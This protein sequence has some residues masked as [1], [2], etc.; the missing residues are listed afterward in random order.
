MWN[1]A[2]EDAA[3][4]FVI[5]HEAE[6]GWTASDSRGR[7][8]AGDVVSDGDPV[9][10]VKPHGGSARWSDLWLVTLQVAVTT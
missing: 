1:R 4:E 2:A 9:I 3:I 7:G 10:E 6:H 8:A 5:A